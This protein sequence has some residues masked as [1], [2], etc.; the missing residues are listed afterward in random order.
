MPPFFFPLSLQLLARGAASHRV[1]KQR[2]VGKQGSIMARICFWLPVPFFVCPWPTAIAV[3][4]Y[5]LCS[6]YGS[7]RQG[8]ARG[9]TWSLLGDSY[10]RHMI[11]DMGEFYCLQWTRRRRNFL[12]RQ[13]GPAQVCRRGVGQSKRAAS[14][15]MLLR[16]EAV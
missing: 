5:L 13:S 12:P 11:Q 14:K 1:G 8:S 2:S 7:S 9:R 10:A 16:L 6:K 15:N 3:R 4:T